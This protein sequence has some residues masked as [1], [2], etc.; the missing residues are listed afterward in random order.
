[1]STDTPIVHILRHCPPGAGQFYCDLCLHFTSPE[2]YYRH[3]C[4]VPTSFQRHCCGHCHP[5]C[6]QHCRLHCYYFTSPNANAT[7]TVSPGQNNT[8]N[9]T[10]TIS[11][12][13]NN[14]ATAVS[15][16]PLQR[17]TSSL[18]KI[19][20]YQYPPAQATPPH[21]QRIATK[22]LSEAMVHSWHGMRFDVATPTPPSAQ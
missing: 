15:V 5:L 13:E 14:T 3:H 19:R 9:A 17:S 21:Q 12:G 7:A 2:Q 1:M 10:T 6:E 22:P 20:D 8:A 4:P 18:N 11:P 16:T